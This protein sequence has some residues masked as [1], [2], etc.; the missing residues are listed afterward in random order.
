VLT[1]R[2]TPNHTLQIIK[3]RLDTAR[4]LGLRAT[5]LSLRLSNFHL[6]SSPEFAVN[7]K[8]IHNTSGILAAESAA[9]ASHAA[10]ATVTTRFCPFRL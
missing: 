6:A 1:A 9:S 8:I 7:E 5:S 4:V 2:H 3:G 10:I